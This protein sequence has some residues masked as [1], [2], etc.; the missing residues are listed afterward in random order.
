MLRF[1]SLAPAVLLLAGT[2]EAAPHNA[3]GR[4]EIL[5]V[6]CE[7]F[8]FH[9]GWIPVP[10]T[11]ENS[12]AQYLQSDQ[13]SAWPAVTALDI[14]Q[15]GSYTLWVR[16]MDSTSGRP[17]PIA[18]GGKA[19]SRPLGVMP[20]DNWTWQ[21]ADLFT[22]PQ[23]RVLLVLGD[24][25]GSHPWRADALILAGDPDYVPMGTLAEQKIP[26]A[27]PA[28]LETAPV[29]ET[30]VPIS[31][32]SDGD[33][34]VTLAKLENE[35]IRV[36]FIPAVRAGKGSARP[37]IEVKGPNGWQTAHLNP[38]AESYQVLQARDE[39]V[40]ALP[41]RHYHPQWRHARFVSVTAAGVTAR[42]TATV[43]AIVWR[44]GTGREA[45]VRQVRQAA[46]QRIEIEFH[47]V[48]SGTM[49]AVW[50]LYPGDRTIRV[51][52][53]FTPFAAGQYSLGYHLFQSRPLSE[54]DELLMPMTVQRRR[55]PSTEYTMLQAA[56]PTPVSLMQ[57]GGPEGPLTY[58]VS[59][60]PSTTPFEFPTSIRSRF[61]LHIRS[62][63][64]DV[65]PSIYGPLVGTPGARVNAGEPLRFA[66]RILVQPGDWYAAYRTTADQVFGWRD[67]R[68][69]GRVSMTEAALNMVDL[70]M[71]D[72][73][74]GWWNRAKA[75]YQIESRNSATQSS[76]L[77]AVSLFRLTGDEDLWRRRTLPTLEYILSR[78]NTH[79]SPV[80]EDTGHY[81]KGS[82]EGPVRQ[83][84]TTVY[85]GI[86]ELLNRRMP[87]WR[88]IAIPPG[89]V[90]G[91]SLAPDPGKHLQPFDQWLGRYLATG[92][93]DSL[94]RAIEGA[95]AYIRQVIDTPPSKELGLPPFFLI[96]FTP[97][98]E[99]LLRLYEV[100]GERRYLDAAAKGARLTMTG[101]WTQPS[102]PGGDVTIHRG[103]R[104]NGDK[105]NLILDK[106]PNRYRLGWP[107]KPDSLQ[108]KQVPAWLVSN[109]GM[110]FEQP[111]TYTYR[112]QGGRMIFQ[113]P[114]APGFLR[115]AR[116]TGD[117][118]F[119][120]YARNAVL[121][122]WGN[123]PGYYYTDFTD[124]AQFPRYPYEGPDIGF[125]YYHH[126][127]VHL[128]WTLDYLVSEAALLSKGAIRFPGLR[129][130]GYAY[131]DNLVYGHAPGEVLGVKDAWL[132]LRKDLV[133][134][135]NPQINYLTAHTRDKFL[136]ILMNESPEQE[137]V[138]VAFHP[139]RINGGATQFTIVRN[140]TDG[141]RQAALTG[142]AGTLE[143]A[144]HGLAVLQ[145]D[146]VN[147][148][149]PAHRAPGEPQPASHPG[150]LKLP[151][152]PGMELRAAAIQFQP[153]PWQAYIW[154]TAASGAL[155]ECR[156]IWH[157]GETSGELLDTDY[158][159]EFSIPV[160]AGNPTLRFRMTGI[161]ADGTAFRSEESALGVA[162]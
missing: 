61:G 42:T 51:Q 37:V 20:S 31:P 102:P 160:Q 99:G 26:A 107:L 12:G 40:M 55:F 152:A 121:G 104:V 109:A 44:A 157:A 111:S 142:N 91:A 1:I 45:I 97:D 59:A 141:G 65:Q 71:D 7:Q 33:P 162:P 6:E 30:P 58:G 119:R 56:A 124:L 77:T 21:K 68:R 94:D 159:Y 108:E 120:I 89:G 19:N 70:Y 78:E 41:W 84:G 81:P 87:L 131:F 18:V 125:F 75:P 112:E 151:I 38:S 155:K 143:I 43:D 96:E 9:G 93:K 80:P 127:L 136:V 34:R 135:D 28:T 36:S 145:I 106:G 35:S 128:S 29:Q 147:I 46:S 133:H 149:L 82:M 4:S 83:Y 50:E 72:E 79:F 67:Y 105:L 22:L 132:W 57:T 2:I 153:G 48:P 138:K 24:G 88:D 101:M 139:D 129:Q 63:T 90:V 23:G 16:T 60:D 144:P 49:R 86:W 156:L 47:A 85:A 54:V 32:V 123:Y 100:T 66:F 118:Q 11:K 62:A 113:A 126:I 110:G 130:F 140:L 3:P 98:W 117:D 39:T 154:S 64:G 158:P 146:N 103:G 8:Q 17:F 25:S 10:G 13:A 15:A 52:M 14:P 73:Y 137:R 69:N 76:P 134:L 27:R 148:D 115:L 150:F 92:E 95:N 161:R 74:G 53:T 116:Y 122:R 5:G 114:W